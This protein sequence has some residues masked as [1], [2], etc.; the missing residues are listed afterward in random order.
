MGRWVLE[1]TLCQ[2][3]AGSKGVAQDVLLAVVEGEGAGHAQPLPGRQA[4]VRAAGEGDVLVQAVGQGVVG[5]P[6]DQGV[7]AVSR[8]CHS[9]GRV[10]KTPGTGEKLLQH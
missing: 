3:D 7:L 10:R 2:A 9:C 6:R 5:R 1:L 4:G 8:G